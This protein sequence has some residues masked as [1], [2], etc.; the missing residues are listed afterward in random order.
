MFAWGPAT[1][2]IFACRFIDSY[3]AHCFHKKNQTF[4]M[5]SYA[6][7][8]FSKYFDK[9]HEL[10][11]FDYAGHQY[12]YAWRN[13]RRFFQKYKFDAVEFSL[14]FGGHLAADAVGHYPWGFLNRTYDHRQ[15]FAI[16]SYLISNFPGNF[17][18]P[19]VHEAAIVFLVESIQDYGKRTGKKYFAQA[20]SSEVEAAVD[21]F[22]RL[23]WLEGWVMNFN[24]FYG[25]E[26]LDYNVYPAKSVD[27]VKKQ[28]N[29]ARS[30]VLEAMKHWQHDMM[31]WESP[32][33]AK[34]YMEGYIHYLFSLGECRPADFRGEGAD[35]EPYPTPDF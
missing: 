22:H 2:Q 10:H 15:E 11:D 35:N 32:K 21:K 20:T 25:R 18:S 9:G 7:D 24:F 31:V 29:I 8:I 5:G 34:R 4:L 6:P 12:R 13:A 17:K 28:L 19:R 23:Q 1:H 33:K 14:G 3:P 27:Q 30:C 26:M 16:D